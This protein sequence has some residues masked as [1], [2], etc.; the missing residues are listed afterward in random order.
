MEENPDFPEDEN[1]SLI[2][3]DTIKVFV[4]SYKIYVSIKKKLV[5]NKT[6]LFTQNILNLRCVLLHWYWDYFLKNLHKNLDK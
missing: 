6:Y 2:P 1:R 3:D 5:V 4:D